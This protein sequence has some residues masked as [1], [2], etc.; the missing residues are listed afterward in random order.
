MDKFF[1]SIHNIFAKFIKNEKIMDLIRKL[2]SKEVF[3][4]LFFGV[5]TTVVNLII[6]GICKDRMNILIA[7]AIAW[8]GAVV[9]AFVTNKLFVFESKSWRPSVLLKEIPTFAGARLLTLGLEELGLF[10]MVEWLHLDKVLTLPFVSGE[11]IIKLMIAVVVVILNYVFSKLII[12]RKKDSS[13][14]G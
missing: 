9:F 6:F 11:M 8:V 5:L 10:V 1:E 2:I 3:S 12:F 7:N 14:E 13:K 4:Y